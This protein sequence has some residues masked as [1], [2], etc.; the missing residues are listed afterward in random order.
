MEGADAV[1]L[2]VAHGGEARTATGDPE[3]SGGRGTTLTARCGEI[4][5]GGGGV[6]EDLAAAH[7]CESARE[8]R[9]VHH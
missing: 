9:S 5:D 2:A 7:L 6:A 1:I 8:R 4:A 3:S